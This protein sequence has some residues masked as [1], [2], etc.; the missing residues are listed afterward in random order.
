MTN[1]IEPITY[2]LADACAVLGIGRT[3]IYELI[4][5]G[6]LRAMKCGSRTLVCAA[7]VRAYVA[8]LPTLPKK[9]A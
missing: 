3:R 1:P 9:A 6:K 2:K 7:S 4:G 5:D 8:S